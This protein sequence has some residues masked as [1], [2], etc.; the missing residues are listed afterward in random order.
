MGKKPNSNDIDLSKTGDVAVIKTNCPICL[1]YPV[2]YYMS[3]E[4][5]I[6]KNCPRCGDF[7]LT[8]SAKRFTHD[9][10]DREECSNFIRISK[11]KQFTVDDLRKYIDAVTTCRHQSA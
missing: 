10:T 2:H 4:Q 6:Y 5:H 1:F 8:I 3:E 11:R 9:I 7:G